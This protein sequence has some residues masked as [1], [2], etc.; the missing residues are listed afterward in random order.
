MVDIF[1]YDQELLWNNFILS[2][3]KTQWKEQAH[4]SI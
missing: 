4:L 2:L 1:E 3:T